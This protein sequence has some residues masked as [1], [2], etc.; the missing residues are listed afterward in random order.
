VP[1]SI[2]NDVAL[3]ALDIVG[4]TIVLSGGVAGTVTGVTYESRM[5]LS[6]ILDQRY[7]LQDLG[8]GVFRFGA[9]KLT[10]ADLVA[11]T[12]Q[13]A[14]LEVTLTSDCQLGS[15]GIDPATANCE[16]HDVSSAFVSD[17]GALI[18]P[19]V[20]SGAVNVVNTEPAITNCPVDPFVVYWGDPV[21]HLF[22]ATD[23]D[24][25]CDCDALTWSKVSGPGTISAGGNYQFVAGPLNIGC[26]TVVVRVDDEFGG[27]ATCEFDIS[28]LN[29]PPVIACPT[30][31]IN[32]LWGETAT[33]TVT[34]DDP[35]DGPSGLTYSMV[36]FTGPGAPSIDPISGEFEWATL[37]TM[38]YVGTFTA[39][40]K[41][42]DGAKLDACNTLNADTCCFTIN[43]IPTFAVTIEKLH[44]QLQGH[45]TDV[46][47][48]LDDAY[49]SMEMGGFDFLIS[50][51]ASA[52]SFVSAEPGEM[53][54]DCEWEY[55]TYRFGPFGNCGSGC[56]SGL[57]RIV[58]LAETNNG[59]SH[60]DCFNN[61]TSNE[62]AILRFLVSNDRTYECMYAPVRF[63]WLDCGDNTISSKLGDTLF[64]ENRVFDF[65]GNE[66]TLHDGFPSYTGT[67]DACLIGDK[68][69][70]LRAINFINGGVDIVCADSIDAR[71]DINVNGLAYEIA[72]A[73]MYTN[74][75]ING[76]GVFGDH[77]E[78][79]IAASDANADGITLSVADLVYLVRVV[80]GDA[81]P[82]PKASGSDDMVVSTQV[83]N[84]ELTV[85]YSATANA[86]AALLVFQYDGTVGSPVLGDGASSM[87]V[88]TGVQGNEL[89]VLVYNIGPNAIS[90]GDH[91]LLN[92][93]VSGSIQLVETQV[94]DF[95]GSTM[96]VS[97]RTLPSNFALAQNYP[98][99][100][101]PS[102]TIELSLPVES[103]YS[104]TLYNIAG[105]QVR[106]FDGHSAAGVVQVLWD[107]K[108][109]SGSQV[110]SGMY[111]YKATAG[112]FSET[113]KMVLM[114]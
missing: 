73:V 79:S 43:V 26:N 16:G 40:V 112:R 74:Y 96:N 29:E 90:A 48:T 71:G 20:T 109:A 86:G 6:N 70:P 7:A 42:S 5:N 75:F 81:Q 65:E 107:G 88:L 33:A 105:Q 12:G 61:V 36:S 45:Y 106:T 23:P 110:A 72:D 52:L 31:A 2:G 102:T 97:T 4:K 21:I 9:I 56:P 111:F 44:D 89:R 58:A 28:V 57:L 17:V 53:L 27:F 95:Y 22:T 66:I 32:I 49:L 77:I 18:V 104:V 13:V 11:G 98:N 10:G 114:K 41:V 113:K 103:D 3:S 93:P 63:Y 60:P 54:V 1:V 85:S 76:L 62:L 82:Y 99:P 35:D 14:S 87:D 47:I 92:I 50:Y 55:F 15:L 38:A 84:N 37:E 30:E 39:C 100:F 101:N 25:A 94:A 68:V 83:I 91:I 64:L 46:H 67:S 19:T 34:A 51:D 108:D 24:L 80:Q 59:A 78:A 8:G 69:F